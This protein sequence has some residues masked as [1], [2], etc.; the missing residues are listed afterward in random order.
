MKINYREARKGDAKLL[1]GIYNASFYDDYIKYGV[2]PGYGKTEQDME[3]LIER[4]PKA[5]IYCNHTPVGAFSVKAKGKGIYYLD[6]LCIIPEYQGKNIGTQAFKHLLSVYSD[7][8]EITLVTPSDKK[9]NI[10]FYTEKC[11]FSIVGKEMD[12]E[13]EVANFRMER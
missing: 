1:A 13:V 3:A 8:K 9:E 10:E 6:C 5:I 7:W 2:C 4:T 11:G 12:G